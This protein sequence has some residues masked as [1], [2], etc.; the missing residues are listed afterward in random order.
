KMFDAWAADYDYYIRHGKESF[1]FQGYDAVLDCIVRLTNPSADMRILDVGVGTG[2]LAQRFIKFGCSIWGV[3]YSKRMLEEAE[4]KLPAINLSHADIRS[5]WPPEL[6]IGFDRIVSAYTLHHLRIKSKV[7]II[8][9]MEDE[10]LKDSGSI[11][12][13]DI[14]FP[15]KHKRTEAREKLGTAWDEDEFYWAADEVIDLISKSGFSVAYE[16]ISDYG[17]VYVFK[18]E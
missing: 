13:G 6:K 17:G 15:T 3:D 7:K 2:N 14:S 5:P 9:R 12:V 16:Q 11:I 18:K 4:K 1:P 10:L 8:E